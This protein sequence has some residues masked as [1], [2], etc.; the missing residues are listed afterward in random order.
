MD[1]S[2]IKELIGIINDSKLTTFEMEFDGM[3]LKMKKG[4]SS[5][6]N[7]GEDSIEKSCQSQS[8]ERNKNDIKSKKKITSNEK[9]VEEMQEEEI[10]GEMV[11]A[12][13]V[14][15]FY[16][17]PGEGKDS[18]IKVGDQVKKG[19]VICIL[20]AMK[21]MNEIQ[22][23]KDGKVVKILVENEQMV[24]YGQPLFIIE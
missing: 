18:F 15:T 16:S 10:N 20:E 4:E 21:I 14:G 6:E 3:I 1:Y 13:L 23:P 7:N 24:E 5:S 11:K 12:P 2:S 9:I 8:K 17:S 22:S 19:D